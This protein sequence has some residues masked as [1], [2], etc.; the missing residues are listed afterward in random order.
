M[1][2]LRAPLTPDNA[3]IEKRIKNEKNYEMKPCYAFPS[4]PVK[5]VDFE[6]LPWRTEF[7]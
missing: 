6:T 2:A 3:T 4:E 5:T 7:V 1:L